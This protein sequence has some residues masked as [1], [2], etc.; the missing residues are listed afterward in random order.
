MNDNIVLFIFDFDGT[1]VNGHSHYCVGKQTWERICRY[2]A[3]KVF[4]TDAIRDQVMTELTNYWSI[5]FMEDFLNNEDLGW[6]NKEQLVRLFK[7]IISS[8]HKIAIA[9]FNDYP[10][11]VKYAL[12]QL[13]GKEI[14]ENIYIKSKLPAGTAQEIQNC[15]EK[16]YIREII[17]NT[18]ITNKK[19]RPLLKLRFKIKI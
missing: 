3:N 19:N 10:N 4:D 1:L 16:E 2:M 11:A 17:D 18:G 9:S 7:N 8:G 14:V 12:E 15:T 6:K 13:L 5:Q